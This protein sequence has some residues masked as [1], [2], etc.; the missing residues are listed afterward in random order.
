[1][2]SFVIPSYNSVNTIKIA[3]ESI[4]NQTSDIKYE[5]I[6]VDDGSTDHTEEVLK[7]YENDERIKYYKKENSGVADTRNFG[8][9]KSTGDYIIFVDSDDYIS[10]TLLKDIEDY[11]SQGVELIKWNVTFVDEEQNDILKPESVQFENTTGEQGF[12]NLFGKDS[13]IDCLWNYA[14]KKELMIEFPS[15]TYH[16]D[17]AIMPLIILNAKSFVSI[18]KRE[19]FYVQSKNSIMREVNSEKTRKKLQDK[20]IHFDN[21]IRK[22]NEMDLSK[23]TKENFGI[24]AVNSL[25]AVVKDLEGEDKKF[26]QKELKKRKIWK[27]IKVRNLKQLIKRIIFVRLTIIL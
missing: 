3:I 13:L 7:C 14:I 9:K 21:L 27:Y 15:G 17:F 25:L 20:L 6:V 22:A 12:N 26:Y 11:I 19:Y 8:V 16:E 5:I 4:L 23:L 2:I 24:Y 18:D 10:K 1:M